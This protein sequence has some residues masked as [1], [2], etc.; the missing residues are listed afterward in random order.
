MLHPPLPA[1][2]FWNTR[3]I[4]LHHEQ[5]GNHDVVDIDC[6]GP[7]AILF[8]G[9]RGGEAGDITKPRDSHAFLLLSGLQPIVERD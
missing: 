6:C 8:F 9:D 3:Q 2:L 5:R 1:G 7:L 4:S